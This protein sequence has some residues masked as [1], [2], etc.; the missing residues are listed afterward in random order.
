MFNKNDN[1][2]NNSH[3]RIVPCSIKGLVSINDKKGVTHVIQ[4]ELIMCTEEEA[5]GWY[6][7]DKKTPSTLIHFTNGKSCRVALTGKELAEQ[8]NIE[9]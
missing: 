1:S 3:N 6:Y 5:F 9:N 8:L 7:S 4:R 2:V